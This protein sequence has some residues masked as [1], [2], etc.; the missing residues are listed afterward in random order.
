MF[1]ET[2]H[3]YQRAD[4][5][6]PEQRLWFA[7]LEQVKKDIDL[8]FNKDKDNKLLLN[9]I[10]TWMETR[11]FREVCSMAN[12]EPTWVKKLLNTHINNQYL[13]ILEKNIAKELQ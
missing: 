8:I 4:V 1:T 9:D 10:I 6:N 12:V 2:E 11:G 7:V 3:G 5:L 13:K